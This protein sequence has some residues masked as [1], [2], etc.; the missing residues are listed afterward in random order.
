M[1]VLTIVGARPQFIKASVVSRRLKENSIEELVLHTGQHFDKNMSEIFFR[2]LG[3]PK[4]VV[5]LDIRGRSHAQ[6]TG[7][8]LQEIE[9]VIV[10][11]KPDRVLVYGDTNSTL[12]G[13]LAAAKLHVPV[14][15]I[16]A[17]LRS[18]N[19]RMPE[20]VNRILT[21]QISD[22]LFCPTQLSVKNLHSEG[23]KKK[24]VDIALV[25]D[26]MFDATIYFGKF[27]RPPEG[28]FADS[29]FVLST[30]HRAENTDDP[31]RLRNIVSS[32]NHIHETVAPVIMP[33]HPRTRKAMLDQGLRPKFRILEPFGYLEMMWMQKQASLILTDSGGIQKEAFFLG[34]PCLTLRE[35]TEWVELV[36]IG[37]NELVGADKAKIIFAAQKWFGSDV[38]GN[39]NIYGMGDS[40]LKIAKAIKYIGNDN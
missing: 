28:F 40:A 7:Q 21:D 14:S 32:L 13:A 23:F 24:P 3:V 33:I 35:E 37:A 31:E 20:E 12:A 1:Q 30:V 22:Q 34:T 6:M 29:Q 17:G 11:K 2:Q 19:M 8:M 18:F 38:P 16:E 26:V 25:G 39:S 36:D 9:S 27:A 10:E 5:E 4:P 15:H